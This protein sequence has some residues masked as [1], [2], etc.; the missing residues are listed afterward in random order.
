MTQ[1]AREEEPRHPETE[2]LTQGFDP[3]LSVGPA[4]G[5]PARPTSSRAPEAAERARST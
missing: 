2:V 3:M 5:L 4:G 1:H